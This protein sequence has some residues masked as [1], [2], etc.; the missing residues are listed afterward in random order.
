MGK[1]IKRFID[2]TEEHGTDRAIKEGRASWS[3]GKLKYMVGCR[4]MGFMCVADIH[5]D[6]TEWHQFDKFIVPLGYTQYPSLR[7]HRAVQA[8][9]RPKHIGSFIKIVR[10]G[11]FNEGISCFLIPELPDME[12]LIDSIP[13]YTEIMPEHLDK[14]FTVFIDKLGIH[15]LFADK[16]AI[17]NG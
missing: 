11:D 3:K 12:D 6:E 9:I 8:K 4:L 7:T 10:S 1:W 13:V 5:L 2:G 17:T 16:G 15:Y 14:W